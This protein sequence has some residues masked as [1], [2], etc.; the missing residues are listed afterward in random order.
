MNIVI[1]GYGS[2]GKLIHTKYKLFEN[3]NICGI[4]DKNN[5][6]EDFIRS[7]ID[8]SNIY[9]DLC[10]PS[11]Y[12]FETINK[13]TKLNIQNFIIPKTFTSSLIQLEALVELKKKMD[14]VLLLRHSGIILIY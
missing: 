1:V 2:Y 7:G 6:I 10:I 11:D 5:S 9:F 4:I 3:I 13:Y 12:I 8:I 14:Y